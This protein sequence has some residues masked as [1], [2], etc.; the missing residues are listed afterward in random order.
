MGIRTTEKSIGVKRVYRTISI[1]L[2][3]AILYSVVHLAM[4]SKTLVPQVS[5]EA[6]QPCHSSADYRVLRFSE[7]HTERVSS[8]ALEH[9]LAYRDA[10]NCHGELVAAKPADVDV[11]AIRAKDEIGLFI[12]VSD[13]AIRA[14]AGREGY[15]VGYMDITDSSEH[16]SPSL[17]TG[18]QEPEA[19]PYRPVNASAHPEY[20]ELVDMVSVQELRDIVGNLSV[21]F[22]TRYY[23]SQ[24]AD[25]KPL[26]SV[27]SSFVSIMSY[28]PYF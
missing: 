24:H 6:S 20:K 1:I 15:R 17:H 9:L 14:L 27:P 26:I 12:P 21:R 4:R 7:S 10:V 16:Q 8:L 22:K 18:K 2:I 5:L 23:R 11:Q 28:Y 3:T 19:L 13:E 25:G